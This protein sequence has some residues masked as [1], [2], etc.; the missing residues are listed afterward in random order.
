MTPL[1]I[2]PT[3]NQPRRLDLNN[4]N[5]IKKILKAVMTNIRVVNICRQLNIT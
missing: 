4:P 3:L 2:S 1:K 5:R